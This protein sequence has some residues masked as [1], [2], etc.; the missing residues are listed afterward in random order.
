MLL[1]SHQIPRSRD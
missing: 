1:K